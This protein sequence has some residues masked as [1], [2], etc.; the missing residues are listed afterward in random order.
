MPLLVPRY[1][2]TSSS[3][4]AIGL[5]AL[6]ILLGLLAHNLFLA[7]STKEKMFT[8]FSAIMG[9][10]VILQTFSAY[11]RFIF[12]LTYNRVTL[13]TH[14]LFVIF[15]LFFEDFFS[16]H[17]HKPKLS[18]FNRFSI[19]LIAGYTVFFLIMKFLLPDATGFHRLLDFIRELFVFYTNVLFIFTIATALGWMRTEALL[20]LIAFIPPALLTSIN[21]MN[22]FPFMARYESFIG[23]LMQ[24]NQPIGLS[25]QAILFSLAMGNRY[26]RIKLERQQSV[27]ESRRLTR[28]N[29]ERMEFY[30]SMS[31]ELRTPLTIILGIN[32]QLRNG[33]YGDSIRKN[34]AQFLAIERNCLRLLRQ[35]SA[36]LRLG[37]PAATIQAEPLP[38]TAT[39]QLILNDFSAVAAERGIPIFY[40]PDKGM[41]SL[42]LSIACEDLEALVMNLVSNALKYCP[43]SSRISLDTVLVPEG[44][45]ELSVSDTGPGIPAELQEIIF[46]RYRK[47][48]G[49]SARFTSGL[50]L[51][52]VKTIMENY[53]GSVTLHSALGEGSRFTLRFPASLVGRL[54]ADSPPR[55]E[56]KLFSQLYTVD[57]LPGIAAG[58]SEAE[59][60]AKEQKPRVL[61]VEDN[62]DMRAYIASVLEE[63]FM[64]LGASSG[65]EALALLKTEAVDVIVSDVMMQGMDGHEF[66][67]R[68][69]SECGAFPIPLIFLTARH[70]Q[71]EK[72]ESLKKGAIR[73]ITKPFVPAELVA[74]IDAILLHDRELAHSQVER[75]RKE[76][77][78]ILQRVD[79]QAQ[80]DSQHH[81]PK[82]TATDAFLRTQSLSAREQEVVRCIIA[83]MSDKEIAVNL[84]ISSRTV[85]NHN[86]TIYRKTGVG[87]R[88]ELI[89]KVLTY[90]AGTVDFSG[91]QDTLG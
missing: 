73:Y 53:E 86:R 4:F 91:G 43:S 14:L 12:Y 59:G 10:L 34:A 90:T 74:G 71:E 32:E 26:N 37:Q 30:T 18:K 45:L 75:I 48:P 87:T 5:L 29:E 21:A 62:R 56:R 28:L 41:G 69:R 50:G 67:A 36:M 78:L 3:A 80:R 6:G 11:E 63:R 35:V 22:I 49:T 72:V 33:R 44:D 51:T 89:S 9:L 55:A 23:F 54:A 20:L 8:Y 15:L 17:S 79:R 25:L 40:A 85:A 61:V 27:E 82:A 68:M 47:A 66:L 52:V 16:L 19:Y 60:P 84:G 24:Y 83:G 13:I 64:V 31:H 58:D 42:G 39:I 81:D 88:F 77:E 1:L 7:F 76:V 38:L 46:Q 2:S 57:L 65:E 70:S